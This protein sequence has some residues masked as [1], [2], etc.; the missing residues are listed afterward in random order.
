MT[1]SK[2]VAIRIV[3]AAVL[4]IAISLFF[5]ASFYLSLIL[6]AGLGIFGEIIHMPENMPGAADNPDGSELHPTKTIFIGLVVVLVLVGLGV[7]FPGLYS[8]G[9]GTNS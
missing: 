5:E 8:Y 4:V 3:L 6:V 9:F 2:W 7:L 1:K